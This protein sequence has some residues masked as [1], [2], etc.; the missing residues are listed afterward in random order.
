MNR[1]KVSVIVPVYNVS[2]YIERCSRSLFEQTLE[3]IEFI[4][5]DD[6][7][8]D[9]SVE[10]LKRT[11]E[12]YPA[13]ADKVSIVRYTENHGPSVAR[14]TG[15]KMATGEY[16]A[17]CDSDDWVSPDIYRQLYESGKK[18]DADI[19][20]CDYFSV[21]DGKVRNEHAPECS[22]SKEDFLRKYIGHGLTV[23]WDKIVRRELLSVNNLRFPDDIVY[24]EDFWFT[25]RLIYQSDKI[26]KIDLPLYYY[27]RD[28]SSSLLN[29][30]SSRVMQD[31]LKSYLE[32]IDFFSRNGVLSKFKKEMSWR[33]LGCKQDLVL[34]KN[35]HKEFL[36][37]YPESHSYILSCPNHFSNRKIKIMMWLLVHHFGFFVMCINS[38]RKYLRRQKSLYV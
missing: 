6:C 20:Y 13:V 2:H 14:N 36:S 1:F 10:V 4:F 35:K 21:C 37:I 12:D 24:C 29:R 31:M 9:D 38:V 27:N 17:F 3:D 33:I 19:C 30:S 34:D 8:N 22:G 7:S 18:A 32:T 11:I 16:V 15:L 25:V 26:V 28:N 23:L 5:I